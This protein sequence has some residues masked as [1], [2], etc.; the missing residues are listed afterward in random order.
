MRIGVCTKANHIELQD[1]PVPEAGAGFVLVRV[2]VCGICG[3]DVAAWQGSGHKSYPYTPGHE[4]C[5]TIERLGENVA[6][7]T[8]G[9]RVV[10]D[11]NLGC[12]Q[13]RFCRAGRPNLCDFLKAR[14]TKSNGGLA[15]F[16]ALDCRMVHPLPDGFPDRLAPFIEPLSCAL[17]AANSADPSE[18]QRVLVFG[19]GLMGLLTGLALRRR[20]AEP[21]F[22][23][24]SDQRR[25]RASELLD[26]P[27]VSPKEL[28]A[29]DLAGRIGV[30]VDCSGSGHAVAQAIRTLRKAGRLV[31]AGIVMNPAE[32]DISLIDVTTKELD[33]RGVWLNP[34]T[35]PAAIELATASADVLERLDTET[36]PLDEVAAAFDRAAGAAAAKVLVVP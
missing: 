32:A 1:R 18:G 23:E 10:I 30:A 11:P 12:K 3:S 19:A 26:A 16:V 13:C 29:S 22:V 25:R 14:P 21:T 8:V 33:L 24:P 28:D 5:G 2:T 15:E 9:R 27:A 17:H 36:F 35:F 34:N 20:G 7:L 31:L 6:G 4:F